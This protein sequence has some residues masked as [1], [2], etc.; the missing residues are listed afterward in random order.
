MKKT[1][2]LSVVAQMDFEDLDQIR[3][4]WPFKE[5]PL[6]TLFDTKAES[7][8]KKRGGGR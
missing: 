1:N 5:K 7:P 4:P 8:G 3:S 2:F 6:F